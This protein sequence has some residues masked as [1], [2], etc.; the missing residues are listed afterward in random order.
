MLAWTTRRQRREGL[1]Q[2]AH[3]L[4]RSLLPDALPAVEGLQLASVYRPAI[5]DSEAGGDFYDAFLR[6]SGCWL[7]VGDVCGKDADAAALTAMV[8]HSIRA[9][10]FR[11]TS[12]AQVL[13]TVNEIMLS[14]DLAVRFA[15]AIV[16]RID[17]AARPVRATIASAGHPPPVLLGAGLEAHCPRV[18]GTFLGVLPRPHLDDVEVSLPDGA[19]L[20]LYTDGLCDAGAPTRTLSTQELCSQLAGH[21]DLAPPQLTRLLEELAVVRGGGRLRDDIAILAVRVGEA[22]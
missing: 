7:V 14:H 3:T 11:E 8:R 2:V 6:P 21:A 18:A 17:L 20:V 15:T 12:P 1:F 5:E 4:E 9:L 19:T 13:R 16:A 22:A 10:A